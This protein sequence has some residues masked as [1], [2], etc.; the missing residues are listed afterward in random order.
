MI[1][2]KK[3]AACAAAAMTLA[4]SVT[5]MSASAAQKYAYR[6]GDV[7]GDK[8]INSVDTTAIYNHI[9]GKKTIKD[10]RGLGAADVNFDGKIDIVD[11]VLTVNW[12]NGYVYADAD[13]D[14]DLVVTNKDAIAIVDHLN[15]DKA[16]N[17]S[18]LKWADVNND[19]VV[20]IEDSVM[21]MNYYNKYAK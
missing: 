11:A 8:K 7:N 13:V 19:K 14:G 18:Q 5:A 21:I 17:K 12:A 16:L 1:N 15:G 9:S 4:C 2:W 3:I 20:D 10:K 6:K